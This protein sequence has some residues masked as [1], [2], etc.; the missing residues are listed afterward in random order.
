MKVA[1][2]TLP[3]HTNYGGILQNYALCSVI[4]ALGY[5]P[6]SFRWQDKTF[7][8][9]AYKKMVVYAK[10][11]F[12]GKEV[13][14]EERLSK[15]YPIISGSIRK[16]VNQ[17]IPQTEVCIATRE[18]ALEYIN[19]HHIGAII[20]GSDQ[21][22]RKTYKRQTVLDRLR[23]RH[24]FPNLYDYYG[25]FVEGSDISKIAYAAS[26]GVDY[27]EYTPKEAKRIASLIQKFKAVSVREESA[28]ALAKDIYKWPVRPD[29]VLDPTFLLDKEVYISLIA[30]AETHPVKGN[31]FA[32]VLDTM[33]NTEQD[34]QYIA[35]EMG[36]SCYSCLM[37][38]Q[39]AQIPL[40]QRVLPSVEQW[41]RNIADAEYIVTDSFH[42]VVYAIIFNKPFIVVGNPKRGNARFVSILKKLGLQD[43]LCSDWTQISSRMRQQIDWDMV[44][45]RLQVARLASM[46]YLRESL[47]LCSFPS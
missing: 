9:P 7:D 37:H 12:Q 21:I 6:E 40:E 43:R 34:L 41:L 20:F 5:S 35:T 19:A 1:V 15:E 36:G 32:Y 25:A 33:S 39:N 11:Y 8:I 44:N 28:V 13:F 47:S 18:K 46:A 2:L 31:L 29:M 16:F 42:A 26:F 14:L 45:S 22:W 38:W 17:Y 24:L 10:R 3:L 30:N 27:Q 4:K 23:A